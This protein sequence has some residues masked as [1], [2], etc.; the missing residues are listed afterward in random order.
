[1]SSMKSCA[2]NEWI[3]SLRLIGSNGPVPVAGYVTEELIKKLGVLQ[4]EL[5]CPAEEHL[6]NLA[7]FLGALPVLC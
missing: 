4:W 3:Q 5:S 7:Q 1:M 2:Q 6:K